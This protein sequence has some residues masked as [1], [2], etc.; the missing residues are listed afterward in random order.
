VRKEAQMGAE[1]YFYVVD[2][3]G[4]I[5]AA[6]DQLRKEVFKRGEYHGAQFSPASPEEALEVTGEDGA[7]SILDIFAIS[8]EPGLCTAAPLSREELLRYFGTDSPTVG[9]VQECV[10][11][12]E[13]IERGTARYV[14]IRDGSTP[15]QIVF[16]G[17][18]FD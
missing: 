17:Y 2:Y 8:D 12:W 18:S 16:A 7:R 15:V 3:Q 9:M 4:N 1:P 14:T 11:F 5:Q 6:L 10:E 13:D